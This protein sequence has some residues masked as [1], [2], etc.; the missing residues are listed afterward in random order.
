MMHKE[1][2]EMRTSRKKDQ[3]REE[4]ID[5]RRKNISLCYQRKILVH[6]ISV[7]RE[8]RKIINVERITHQTCF[9]NVVDIYVLHVYV[10][11]T[12]VH[13]E[14][15]GAQGPRIGFVSFLFFYAVDF[16]CKPVI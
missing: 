3:R 5:E 14:M 11:T 6:R 16:Y 8:R 1:T 15:I 10:A 7:R 13:E 9:S 2:Y 12:M 4:E